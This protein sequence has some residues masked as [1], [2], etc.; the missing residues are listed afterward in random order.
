MAPPLPSS[1]VGHAVGSP[2]PKV[3]VEAFL[4]LNCPF[5]RKCFKTLV[6]GPEAVVAAYAGQ[7]VQLVLQQ[8]IQPVRTILVD[9]LEPK[10][11]NLKSIRSPIT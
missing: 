2:Q 5:S 1:P 11:V 8:V 3:V 7:P 6:E 10:R 9:A 4:D